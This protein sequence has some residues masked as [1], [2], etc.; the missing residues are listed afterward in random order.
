MNRRDDIK[1]DL[2]DKITKAKALCNEVVTQHCLHSTVDPYS[3]NEDERLRAYDLCAHYPTWSQLLY[4]AFDL[5][6]DAQKLAEELADIAD[7]LSLK[8]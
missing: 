5:L 7:G 2:I 4:C 3:K 6:D 8:P 1:I